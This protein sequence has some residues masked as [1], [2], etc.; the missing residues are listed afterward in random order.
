MSWYQLW[1]LLFMAG[2]A[3]GLI[4]IGI[5]EWKDR[6]WDGKEE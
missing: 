4:V 1:A 5:M 2:T 6:K 3:C